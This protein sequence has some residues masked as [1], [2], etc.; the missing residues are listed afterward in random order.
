MKEKKLRV[1]IIGTGMIANAAH[2][3]AYK[4]I[5]DRVEVVAVADD[6]LEAASDTAKRW[7]VPNVY[8]N[9]QKM[10]DEMNLDLVSICTPN[11]SHTQW[12]I[13]ALR[14]GAHVAC[15][16]PGAITYQD[17]VDMFNEMDKTGKHLFITQTRRFYDNTISAKRIMEE[18]R[19]GEAYFADLEF[20]RRRGVPKWGFFHMKEYNH[21][22]PF[23]DLGVQ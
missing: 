15:E 12:T 22:G 21:G 11:S 2:L 1:G 20:I 6:R 23:C 17:G 18:G 3:P 9:P 5:S 13:A 19:V 8:D 16:K 14:A 4:N 10:L 7:N